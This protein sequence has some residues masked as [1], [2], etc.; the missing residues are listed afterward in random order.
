MNQEN[1]LP[2]IS[3]II[4]VFNGSSKIK[5]CLNYIYASESKE[6]EVI[7]VDDCSSDNTLDVASNYPCRIL[8]NEINKGPAFSR[9]KGVDAAN[10]ELILFVDVDV[11]IPP[12][13]MKKISFFFDSHKEISIL[14]C[15]YEDSPHYKNLFS[16]YKHYIFSY[17]GFS[18]SKSYINYIHTACVVLRKI[19]FQKIR[20]NENLRRREDIDFGLRCVQ[21]GF[22]IYAD[23]EITV[24]HNKKYDLVSFSRYQFSSAKELTSQLL[25]IKN[26]NMSQE[27]HLPNQPLYKKLWF[28]RPF[29]SFLFLLTLLWLGISYTLLPLLILIFIFLSSFLVEFQFRLYLLKI[30]PLF[31]SIAACFLYFYDGLLIGLGVVAG[32]VNILLSRV[33]S[34]KKF[35]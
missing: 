30:A 21:N 35:S 14:Q 26:K 22:L 10:G 12:D 5:N 28:L 29:F 25:V 23:N 16:Q 7:L 27:F 20:F 33:T 34:V 8:K 6:F 9:N 1:I 24:S 18:T 32:L 17:R 4:P 31:I 15:R 19:V 3:I 2:K 13:L 11:L